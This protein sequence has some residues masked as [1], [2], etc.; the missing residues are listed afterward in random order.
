MRTNPLPIRFLLIVSA[1]I[2][3]G[4]CAASL[5]GTG[6]ASGGGGDDASAALPFGGDDAPDDADAA[7]FPFSTPSGDTSAPP[8]SFD[9]GVIQRD[10]E[11]GSGEGPALDAGGE[12]SCTQPLSPGVL[13]I[14]EMMIE[15]VAGTGDYGQWIEIASTASCAVDLNGLHAECPVGSKVRTLDVGEDVWIPP[16]GF[17][18]IADSTDPAINHYLPG[19]VLAWDGDPGSVLRK[20]GGTVSLMAN[21]TI[22]DS[23][24]WPKLAVVVGDSVE[25]PA[26]CAPSQRSDWTEWQN[27]MV[28]WFPGFYGTPNAPNTDV[29]CL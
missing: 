9:A 24:T 15:S 11:A 27:S 5:D 13:V 29:S 23:V 16:G 7:G 1:A 26:S 28:C 18:I 10:A 6:A 4:A 8:L 19:T 21:G 17:F 22:V 2:G 3:G 12:G 20:S 25:F 14:D